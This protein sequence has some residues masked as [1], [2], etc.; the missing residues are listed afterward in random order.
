MEIFK[1]ENKSFKLFAADQGIVTLSEF[2]V[3]VSEVQLYLRKERVGMEC[4]GAYRHDGLSH[5]ERTVMTIK[6]LIGFAI[7]FILSNPNFSTL[8]FMRK[9]VF[10]LWGGLF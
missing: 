8:R 2:Q 7:I 4:D 1:Q 5:S 9:N 3:F 10:Q 6:E